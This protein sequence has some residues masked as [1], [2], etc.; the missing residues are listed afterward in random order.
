MKHNYLLLLAACLCCLLFPLHTVSAD[1]F[2]DRVHGL[3]EVTNVR[4][5]DTEDKVRIVVD[6]DTPVKIKKMV[7]SSP[8]R[9]VV[10]IQNA[11]LAKSQEGYEFHQS[12]HQPFAGRPVRS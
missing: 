5:S 12:L 4:V 11:W 6:A 9:V 1:A 2:D 10:D 8:D 3:T 7:L